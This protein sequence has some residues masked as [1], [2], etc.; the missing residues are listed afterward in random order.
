MILEITDPA[1]KQAIARNVLEA[2]TDW[3]GIEES[4]EEYISGS[5]HWTFL[6]AREDNNIIGFLCLKETGKAT[7]ELAVMGILKDYH[8]RGIGRQLVEKAKEAARKKAKFNAETY[9]KLKKEK[10]Q[11]IVTLLDLFGG[12][13]TL[14]EILSTDISLLNQLR[15]AKIEINRIQ[16]RE[17]EKMNKAMQQTQP[18]QRPAV[19]LTD[20]STL[21]KKGKK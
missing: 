19:K 18:G 20:P 16:A 5:A 15:D 17:A 14:S 10:A 8:R 7:V 3:F 6:A 13:I 9:A 12:E 1:E 4:R 2:L 21:T 11:E